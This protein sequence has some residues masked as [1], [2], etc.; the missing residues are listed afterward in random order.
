LKSRDK[1]TSLLDFLV[2]IVIKYF[3][4]IQDWYNDLDV[5]PIGKCKFKFYDVKLNHQDEDK[6]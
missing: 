5:Q 4:G 1:T 3:P 6:R 2:N